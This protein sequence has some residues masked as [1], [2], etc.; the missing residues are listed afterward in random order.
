MIKF[1]RLFPHAHASRSHADREAPL[2]MHKKA[3]VP[4]ADLQGDRRL[5]ES[6]AKFAAAFHGSPDAMVINRTRDGLIVDMNT[7]YLQFFGYEREEVIGRTAVELGLIARPELRAVFVERL[8]REGKVEQMPWLSRTKSGEVREALHSG[9]LIELGGEQHH[10]AILRDMTEAQRAERALRQSEERLRQ[11]VRVSNIGIFDHDHRDDSIYWSAHQRDIYGWDADEVVTLDKF[12]ACIFHED[13]ARIRDAVLR[14]HHPLGSGSYDV[15][16]RIVRKDGQVRWVTARA[17]TF[18]EGVGEAR[19]PLRTVGA[20]AD[21]TERRH[22][23]QELRIAATA[24]ESREGLIITDANGVILR[25]NQ[26][27]EDLTGYGAKEAIGRNPS[28]LRSDR[29][30][31]DFFRDMWTAIASAGHWQG[32]IWNRRKN[33]EE[34][35]EWLS[36]TAVRNAQGEITNYVA[37]FSDISE[38][39]AAEEQIRN[40]A[41]FDSI[42]RLPNRR[43]LMERLQRAL[44]ASARSG[45]F[46]ALLVIDLDHFKNLNDTRGH[47]VGDKLLLEVARR[48]QTA[49]RAGDIVARL[50]GDEFVIVLDEL[51]ASREQAAAAAES[52]GQKLLAI[53]REPCALIEH[54]T[55]HSASIG[56]SIFRGDHDVLEDV[57]KRADTA[58]YQAKKAGRDTLRF[59]DPRMQAALEERALIE[60]LLRQAVTKQEFALHY[61]VQVDRQGNVLAAEALLRWFQPQRGLIA[62]ARFISVAEE[63]GCILPIG[64]WVMATACAQLRAWASDRILRNVAIAVNVSASQFGQPGFVQQ[65]KEMVSRH[66]VDPGK[67]ELELTESLLVQNIDDAVEKMQALQAF[68]IRFSMD[69]FGTGHSSLNYLKR[70]P[71]DQLKIDRSFVRDIATDPSDA[72]IVQTIVSMG[73]TL[74]MHVI[75]EGVEDET[76]LQLLR[77]YGCEMFQGYLFGMP[78][79]VDELERRVR[80]SG[81]IAAETVR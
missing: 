70:L 1:K 57:L 67:L 29:Q 75:A 15:E 80:A 42:T 44:A 77:A 78:V 20:I 25:V 31:N 53:L 22:A 61:Q 38:Q 24:F 66:G 51:G 62:P 6:E 16:H 26:A 72:V 14:A 47:A 35:P 19:R 45:N 37:N 63:T 50:G 56:I 69:D 12:L 74:G 54:P 55:V 2:Y 81:S 40:L 60:E 52:L 7:A 27:F 65:V 28:L 68:G 30:G 59:F 8:L 21:I 58:M 41:F 11:A 33:G 23:E 76:Q 39:K 43:F 32:E 46:G 3:E 4:A 79:P 9:Y 73:K 17:R 34:F 18:F 64:Q 36:I 10:V 71:L 48:L 5:Q 13:R 49:A